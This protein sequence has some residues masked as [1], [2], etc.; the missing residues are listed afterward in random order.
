[1]S[2]RVKTLLMIGVTVLV[3]IGSI[4]TVSDVLF[5][6]GFEAIENRVA[7]RHLDMVLAAIHHELTGLAAT[8]RDWAFWDDS[9]DFVSG[10]APD[11]PHENTAPESLRNIN[12]DFM[13]F[14]DMHGR[15]VHSR[16]LVPTTT[17]E[18]DLDGALTAQLEE[19]AAVAL[20]GQPRHEIQTCIWTAL[21][22]ALTATC[23]ILT[24][25]GSGPVKGLLLIGRFLGD[26]EVAKLATITRLTV[27]FHSLVESGAPEELADALK[28]WKQDD[29]PIVSR[30]STSALVVCSLMRDFSGT[31]IGALMVSAP[32]EGLS[33]RRTAAHNFMLELLLFGVILG[34]VML[35]ALDRQVLNRLGTLSKSVANIA[36]G[37]GEGL[38][39]QER[40]HDEI[41]ALAHRINEML[42]AL[43]DSSAALR[44]KEAT[45]RALIDA[46]HEAALLFS[47]EGD[48]L[49]LN[50]QAAY[51]LGM[52]REACIGLNLREIQTGNVF[53]SRW[54]HWESVI[55]SGKAEYF[56]GEVDG[57]YFTSCLYPVLNASGEVVNLAAFYSDVTAQRQAA[58][59]LRESEARYHSFV[60]NSNGLAFQVDGRLR[61]LFCHG[62]VEGITGYSERDILRGDV[63]WM[64]IVHPLDRAEFRAGMRRLRRDPQFEP[65]G[66]FRI[67]CKDGSTRW[68]Q[69]FISHVRDHE[70]R[71]ALIQGVL[72]D[73]T[74][75][76]E[77]EEALQ[78]SLQTTSDIVQAIPSG[79]FTF[80]YEAPGRLVLLDG[81]AA[82]ERLTGWP[83]ATCRGKE[84]V[85]L[86][87]A[88]VGGRIQAAAL[89]T[90]T[91]GQPFER[92]EEFP[93]VD[94][95]LVTFRI[96]GF[97]LPGGKVGLGFED[98]TAQRRSE[99]EQLQL[100]EQLHHSHKMEAIGQLA[101]GVAHDFN[102]LLGGILGSASM[103]KL[104]AP[105]DSY[106]YE[107]ALTIEKAAER[108]AE[109][110]RQLLGF[111]R[112][113]KF[114]NVPVDIHATI[115]EVV[116]L[117]GRTIDKSISIMQDLDADA[118][119]VMGDPNQLQQV[120]L[121]L[122]VNARDAMPH[123]GRL[124]FR[125][126]TVHLA[127]DAPELQTGMSPG[128]YIIVEVSDEGV[129]IPRDHLARI[130]EPFF[131]T[132][133][134]GQGT[135]MGLAMVYGIIKNHNGF[136]QVESEPGEGTTFTIHL[137][138]TE[139]K[140]EVKPELDGKVLRGKAHILL[141][142]DEEVV[143]DM[144]AT[145]LRRLGYTVTCTTNG[146]EA[147][148]YFEHHSDEV[149]LAIVDMVMPVMN[150]HDCFRAL[151]RINPGL[152][153]ILS[154]GYAFNGRASEIVDEGMV[155]FIQKPYHVSELSIAVAR[156]LNLGQG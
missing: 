10:R 40:G 116:R 128:K 1:M 107:A 13:L 30:R 57:A 18:T 5:Q 35:V 31:P 29:E 78:E 37:A 74:G 75:N 99:H 65:Q 131:T 85:E 70:G 49:D 28:A 45:L 3:L 130:F 12:L 8:A 123:G 71:P 43:E 77:S 53:A 19:L 83:I 63:R 72:Y 22:P 32:R 122:A 14:F 96:Y 44:S 145:V 104:E 119:M 38:R 143:R 126:R 93:R 103:L 25:D 48:I 153:A 133:E 150:G 102:N 68:V 52:P 79:L 90:A 111:A 73:I 129:G 16:T 84:L 112:R 6:N 108:A 144:C 140:S 155:G 62:R 121:N 113:G 56:E 147:V 151:R 47:R 34:G 92:E 148:D 41:G 9:Y 141:V 39:V 137:A 80:R 106:A 21:G 127:T 110:T 146:Q 120:F 114:Q 115:S 117:L 55:V 87:P 139:A 33:Y 60:E 94:E 154:S 98:V 101:G 142:D 64:D 82:A 135:G 20:L 23:P 118:A 46:S 2:L 91:T 100:E 15:V 109:L 89:Q 66:R 76:V 54:T 26:A 27:S 132:K 7:L 86:W 24:S 51:Y 69:A 105:A 149:D 67:V 81:N 58:N 36:E 156:A 4:Y 125:T 88:D 136:V 59:A 61:P 124:A 11:F 17:T 97:A 138:L 50:A 152:R 42:A 95:T 134:M